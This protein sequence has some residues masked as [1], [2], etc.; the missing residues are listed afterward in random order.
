[1]PYPDNYREPPAEVE[2]PA[3]DA[4]CA[5]L[6]DEEADLMDA[7]SEVAEKWRRIEESLDELGAALDQCGLV[8]DYHHYVLEYAPLTE[9]LRVRKTA[10]WACVAENAP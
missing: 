8:D 4:I 3:L 6:P 5:R 1:M 9:R 2:S 10:T 7:I